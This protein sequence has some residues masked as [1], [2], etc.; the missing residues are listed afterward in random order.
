MTPHPTGS[1]KGE[2][3]RL[4]FLVQGSAPEPYTVTIEQSGGRLRALCT[5]PAGQAG[6][7]CKHRIRILAGKNEGVV[8]KNGS[9]VT[10]AASWLP[11]TAVERAIEAVEE[12]EEA[13]E[14][15]KDEVSQRKKD[16]ARTLRG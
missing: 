15:A 13:L 2:V 9:D 4:V 16:L 8:S 5:C 11:G 3:G 14:L 1:R 6:Q 12:A 7:Y 10:V